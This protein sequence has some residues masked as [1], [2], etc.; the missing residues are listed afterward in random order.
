MV[1]TSLTR[2]KLRAQYIFSQFPT[3]SSCVYI[4]LFNEHMQHFSHHLWFSLSRDWYRLRARLTYFNE[5]NYY[6][7]CSEKLLHKA[8]HA[9]L[10]YKTIII[11]IRPQI[12][13]FG[14]S[15]V[16]SM[17]LSVI[18][19]KERKWTR[20]GYRSGSRALCTYI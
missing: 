6:Y 17:T 14:D 1:R 10:D 9:Q 3:K 2:Y 4:A 19:Y 20:N 13:L 5:Q 7:Y 15:T 11:S 8:M 12:G 18:D 16:C